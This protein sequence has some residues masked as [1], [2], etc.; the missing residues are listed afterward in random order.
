MI[1][2]VTHSDCEA[3]REIYNYYIEETIVT[4]EEELVTTDEMARRVRETSESYPWLVCEEGGEITGYAYART[5]HPRS[6][7]RFSVESSVYLG[8]GNERK[9]LGSA[10]YAELLPRL[11]ALSIHSV[12]AG[13][14]LPNEASVAIHEK[15]GF[16]K[17]AHYREVGRKFDRWIDVG[18]WQLIFEPAP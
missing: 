1:R 18:Y 6:A 9:G 2:P 4:F 7:Y 8:K 16:K 17:A 13:I 5:W 10:L 11:Q 3:I 15:F 12:I 14:S